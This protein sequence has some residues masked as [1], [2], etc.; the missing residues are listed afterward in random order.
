MNDKF[1]TKIV[2]QNNNTWTLY[3]NESFGWKFEK[4]VDG[5]LIF[6]R[7]INQLNYEQLV[8]NEVY[9][10]SNSLKF[11]IFVFIFCLVFF[12]FPGII[13]AIT[14]L[15]NKLGYIKMTKEKNRLL[16]ESRKLAF[17]RDDISCISFSKKMTWYKI[18]K[19]I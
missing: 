18:V 16:W 1:E 14:T 12:I 11:N 8:A 6:K 9:F 13:Y 10:F 17:G 15:S 4:I 5:K 7:D 2:N 19:S 3:V